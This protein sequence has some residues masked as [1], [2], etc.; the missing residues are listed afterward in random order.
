MSN[1]ATWLGQ[2]ERWFKNHPQRQF[3]LSRL[4]LSELPGMANAGWCAGAAS[5]ADAAKPFQPVVILGDL[6]ITCIVRRADPAKGRPLPGVFLIDGAP[7]VMPPKTSG[8]LDE[9]FCASMWGAAQ[10]AADTGLSL[11]DMLGNSTLLAQAAAR[12]L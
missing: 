3:K 2:Q 4:S 1:S 5:V 6:E 8:A 7:F 11:N 10:L 9:A 12:G